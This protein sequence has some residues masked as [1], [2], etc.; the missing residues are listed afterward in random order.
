MTHRDDVKKQADMVVTCLQAK[1]HQGRWQPPEAGI[2]A[3]DGFS[4]TAPRT[5]QPCRH[6]DFQLLASRA[7]RGQM[8]VVLSQPVCG[9]L[10]QQLQE[11]KPPL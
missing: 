6:L 5:H 4:L 3:W 10:L 7:E 8:C 1:G 11:P 2:A 9:T